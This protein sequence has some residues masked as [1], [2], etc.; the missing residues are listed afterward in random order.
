[1]KINKI[2]KISIMIFVQQKSEQLWT[3]LSRTL[4]VFLLSLS[5]SHFFFVAIEKRGLSQKISTFGCTNN[6]TLKI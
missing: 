5:S 4:I 1:M 3:T 6:I 2:L